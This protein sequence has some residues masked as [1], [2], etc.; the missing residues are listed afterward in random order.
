MNVEPLSCPSCSAP[1]P[2][3]DGDSFRCPFC[4][5]EVSVPESY[6]AVR[7]ANRVADADLARVEAAYA[8]LGTPPGPFLRV[9]ARGADVLLW[10][11]GHFSTLVLLLVV[12]FAAPP[13][14]LDA[15]EHVAPQLGISVVSLT[16]PVIAA[17][18]L[19]ALVF[20]GFLLPIEYTHR[21]AL[22][23]GRSRLGAG[24]AAKPPATAGGPAVCRE[25]GA[26]LAVPQGALGVRCRYCRTDNLVALPPE[27]VERVTRKSAARHA[28]VLSALESEAKIESDA[29]ERRSTMRLLT[30]VG[31][32]VCAVL[33]G[34]LAH[35]LGRGVPAWWLASVARKPRL[36]VRE[37]KRSHG[38]LRTGEAYDLVVDGAD[39]DDYPD[40]CGPTFV[41]PLRKGERFVVESA[42]L[43]PN[44]TITAEEPWFATARAVVFRR[45]RPPRVELTAPYSGWFV[46]QIRFPELTTARVSKQHAHLHATLAIQPPG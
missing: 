43:R 35:E 32:V 44:T 22:A 37:D 10:L 6:R 14:A 18:A 45:A 40:A 39:C 42:D 38:E 46:V 12:F 5:A 30:G 25:C 19:G 28:D 24:M 7:N 17:L 20:A 34:A 2:L 41:V 36:V 33:W 8:A 26:P 23:A 4:N 27:W 21:S 31:F 13:A 15:L 9:A 3:E 11:F 16:G 29:H 1:V